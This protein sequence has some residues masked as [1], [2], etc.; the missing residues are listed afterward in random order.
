MF[1]VDRSG[2][3]DRIAS[4]LAGTGA[5]AVVAEYPTDGSDL[6][7]LHKALGDTLPNAGRDQTIGV[8]TTPTG[9][10]LVD[11]AIVEDEDAAAD[12]ML[13]SL[14]G[15]G[16]RCWRFSNGAGAVEMLGGATPKLRA[17]V[18]LLDLNMPAVGGLEVL[19]VLAADGVLKHS[20]VI[21]VSATDDP[22]MQARLRGAGASDY[23][24]KPIDFLGLARAVDNALGRA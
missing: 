6:E 13:H 11:V 9:T 22:T 17:R 23:F 12:L 20:R 15:R 21:V 16:H 2:G 3:I 19:T 18:I 7:A 1:G 5:R 14:N 4:L 10:R 24:V 8:G